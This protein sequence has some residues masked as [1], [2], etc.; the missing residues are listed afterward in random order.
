MLKKLVGYISCPNNLTY[1]YQD[2]SN[3]T[4]YRTASQFNGVPDM[5]FWMLCLGAVV[6]VAVA[7][8]CLCFI[9]KVRRSHTKKEL[10]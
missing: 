4:Y 10:V 7:V 3:E 9:Q 1:L 8:A 6:V 5:P 2:G